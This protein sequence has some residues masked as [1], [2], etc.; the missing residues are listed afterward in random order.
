MRDKLVYRHRRLTDDKVFYIG[1]GTERRSKDKDGRSNHWKS[2]VNKYGRYVEIVADRLT[3]AEALELEAFLIEEYGLSNLCNHTTGGE[4]YKHSEKSKFEMQ[5][6]SP[7]AREIIDK[8]RNKC[9][10]SLSQACE[11][12][13][14][15][16]T[17][18]L[19]Q[20]SGN[21]NRAKWNNLYYID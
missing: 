19:N 9:Y 12:L 5:V 10:S 4:H 7:N 1:M 14:F 8:L 6:K 13:G 15:K 11:E 21:A 18:V 20:L 16:R 17:T 2:T 3:V